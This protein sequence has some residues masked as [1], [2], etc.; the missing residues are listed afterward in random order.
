MD[1]EVYIV[2]TLAG[3]H[4][5]LVRDDGA[6]SDSPQLYSTREECRRALEEWITKSNVP[7]RRVH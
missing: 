5:R 3:W 7:I 6:I 2:E 1:V 4:V